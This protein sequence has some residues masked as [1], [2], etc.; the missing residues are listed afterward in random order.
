[1]QLEGV[2]YVP[3]YCANCG[4]QYGMVPESHVSFVF[5]LCD[6]GCAGRW[7]DLAHTYVDPD[8]LYRRYMIEAQIEGFG[9]LLTP[10]EVTRE[11]AQ[12]ES[13]MA[14]LAADFAAHVARASHEK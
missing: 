1:M 5:A 8:E 3:V 7:G 14:K 9:R 11:L 13:A 12:R 6:Q 4:K 10:E 2:W